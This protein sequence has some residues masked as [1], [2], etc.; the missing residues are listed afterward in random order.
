MRPD[1]VQPQQIRYHDISPINLR[2]V[3]SNQRLFESY[4]RVY[5]T[6]INNRQ[7]FHQPTGNLF[8]QQIQNFYNPLNQQVNKQ[9]YQYDNFGQPH[10]VFN[11]EQPPRQQSAAQLPFNQGSF[12]LNRNNVPEV[13]K[14]NEQSYQY[15]DGE[16]RPSQ[17]SP[18][19]P[20]TQEKIPE[21][22]KV[23][24]PLVPNND[25]TVTSNV[26]ST[27]PR[28]EGL[29]IDDEDCDGDIGNR[30]N[31]NALKSLIG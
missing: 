28:I 7:G 27:R 30:I 5:P 13:K 29:P 1:Y 25:C 17:Q 26:N 2:R 8:N 15:V 16:Q 11:V 3:N 12:H 31:P 19:P 18:Q 9:N 4:N 21:V 6:S 10:A 24:E 20:F 23:N 14:V 22:K